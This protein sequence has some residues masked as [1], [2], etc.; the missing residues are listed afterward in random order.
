[1]TLF[2]HIVFL[3]LFLFCH[4]VCASPASNTKLTV[5]DFSRL[6]DIS[7]VKLSP[8]GR[9]VMYKARVDSE[10]L[11]GYLI[12]VRSLDTGKDNIVLYGSNDKFRLNWVK[13]ADNDTLFISAVFPAVRYGTPTTETRL[14]VLDIKT[15][16]IRNALSRSTY[17]RFDHVPQFQD[18]I[19]DFLPNDPKHFLLQADG[20]IP[21]SP[22]VYRVSL[23]K[24]HTKLIQR[25]KADVVRWVTD[26]EN[27]IRL[28]VSFKGTTYKI[29]HSPRDSK[30]W[31]TLWE[32][33]SFS[34][35]QVWPIGFSKNPDELY[36]SALHEGRDAI[37]LVNLKDE[38]LTKKLVYSNERYDVG[39]DLFYASKTGDPVGMKVSDGR[40]YVFWDEDYK[41]LMEGINLGLLKTNNK[42]ISFSDDERRYIVLATSDTDPGTYYFGDRDK[43]TLVPVAYRYQKLL[44]RLLQPKKLVSYSARDGLEIEAY[45]TLPHH[46]GAPKS[47]PTIIFPHGG[48]ISYDGSGFDYWTQYFASAGYAVLQMNFRGSSGYG[49]DFMAA[50]LQSWGLAMQ[51]DVED[52]ARWMIENG[53]SDPEKI[54]IVGASYGG[55]AALM[56]AV[57]SKDLYKCAVSFAG[58]TDVAYLVK[59]H[60]N[61]TNFKVVKAQIGSDYKSLKQRSPLYHAEEIDIPTLLIHGTK[62]RSV[63]YQHSKKMY[64]AMK[65]AG[66]DVEL[67][68]L[69]DGTHYLI[70]NAH[71][72]HAFEK[73]D[74]FLARYLD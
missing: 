34:A 16:K 10:T 65:K 5:Q 42:L 4:F 53:Y 23:K 51:D 66:A 14:L 21:N 15:K 12:N 41:A 19:L 40:G 7:N 48:P 73:M 22:S 74:E 71:R 9:H 33:E 28:G 62:D 58:V 3:P 17:S 13:W 31:N 26:A 27:N 20:A 57:K 1:M 63:K 68:T 32:F 39:G 55:Y 64:K 18:R 54:C 49:H 60:R 2:K 50:G 59:S 46:E 6:P 72:M 56:G 25:A 37:F 8:D 11:Q 70:K 67:V 43:K 44:P 47:F 61:Y 45:L 52:G 30:K 24:G 69:E 29:I 36:V 35:D 38:S